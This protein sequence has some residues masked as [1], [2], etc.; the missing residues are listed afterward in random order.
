MI[1]E[2]FYETFLE[3]Y[4]R[5]FVDNMSLGIKRERYLQVPGSLAVSSSTP[6]TYCSILYT[7][8]GYFG[9]KKMRRGTSS[10]VPDDEQLRSE[11]VYAI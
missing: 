9:I 10:I 1:D 11:Y 6:G 7:T 8:P 2:M 3:R 4:G 5:V